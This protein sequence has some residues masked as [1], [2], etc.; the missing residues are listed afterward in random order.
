MNCPYCTAR[1]EFCVPNAVYKSAEDYGGGTIVF[2]CMN[3]GKN[4]KARSSVIVELYYEEK[5][6]EKPNYIQEGE[7]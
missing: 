4:I 3:C 6:N 5:T 7:F 1:E 2:E